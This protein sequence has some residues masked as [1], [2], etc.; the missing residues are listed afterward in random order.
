MK[1]YSF[2]DVNVTISHPSVGVFSANGTGLDS[3]TIEYANDISSHDIAADGTVVTNKIIT[4]NGSVVFDIQQTS[5]FH[6]WLLK[7]SNYIKIAQPSEFAL[8]TITINSINLNET[9]QLIGVTPQKLGQRPYKQQTQKVSWTLL[10]QEID[11]S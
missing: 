3:I 1:T 9:T 6:A 8:A 7:W 11:E 4:K 10:A 2:Q 5:E